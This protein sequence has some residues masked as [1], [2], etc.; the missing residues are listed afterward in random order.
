MKNYYDLL[1]VMPTA[2]VEVIKMAYKALARKY[3]PDTYSGDTKYATDRMS[4]IN[5]AYEVLSDSTKRAEY[6]QHFR[7]S[8]TASDHFESS[9]A[10]QTYQQAEETPPPPRSPILRGCFSSLLHGIWRLTKVAIVLF[11]IY[12]ILSGKFLALFHRTSNL[13]E[14]SQPQATVTF[15]PTAEPGEVAAKAVNIYI[16]ALQ[17]LNMDT[18]ESLVYGE[19]LVGLTNSVIEA[20]NSEPNPN[21]ITADMVKAVR[22]F[23]F[24]VEP[25]IYET[26]AAEATVDVYLEVK[27]LY[28][29]MN[30]ASAYYSELIQDEQWMNEFILDSAISGKNIDELS[31]YQECIKLALKESQDDIKYTVR[32]AVQRINGLW[33]ITAID[34]EVEFV[35]VLL[36]YLPEYV[37]DMGVEFEIP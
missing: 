11:L 1:Q 23:K 16:N 7:A 9:S 12:F 33:T 29:V 13:A 34:D 31:I 17:T 22:S 5:E 20:Y 21:D 30:L 19:R 27:N 18:A 28:T 35:N 3:H 10:K 4:E 15:A 32:F 14:P 26:S 8:S 24:T 36:G 37:E 6:D 25:A 2:S